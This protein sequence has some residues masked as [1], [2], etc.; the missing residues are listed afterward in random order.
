M[1]INLNAVDEELKGVKVTGS[2]PD[3]KLEDKSVEGIVHTHLKSLS[4]LR[5][6]DMFR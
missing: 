3:R 6:Y 2:K 4:K 1:E 5:S